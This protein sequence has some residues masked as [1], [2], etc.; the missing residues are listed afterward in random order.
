MNIKI[1]MI[2]KILKVLA[3]LAIIPVLALM[4]I[5]MTA[6]ESTK[7]AWAGDSFS[8]TVDVSTGGGTVKVDLI[9]PWSLPYTKTYSQGSIVTL[10]AIPSFGYTFNSWEKHF[11]STE[12]PAFVEIDCNKYITASFKVDWRLIG[13][14]LGSLVLII[15]LIVVLILRRRSSAKGTA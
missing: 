2:S 14:S 12:N 6:P 5:T 11:T 10:E 3:G 1:T 7:A 4:V 9:E 8:L 13:T 15:F